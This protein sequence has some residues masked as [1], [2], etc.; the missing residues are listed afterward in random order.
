LAG[1]IGV[2]Q[3]LVGN[4][5]AQIFSGMHRHGGGAA[6][7]MAEKD[8]AAVLTAFPEPQVIQKPDYTVSAFR[9]NKLNL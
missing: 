7:G 8:M 4:P 6:V 5:P 2:M 1:D 3:N 9:C